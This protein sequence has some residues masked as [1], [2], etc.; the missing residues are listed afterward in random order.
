MWCQL[1][2]RFVEI[3]LRCRRHAV[4]VLAEE[5][6]VHVKLK[7]LV[8]AQGLFQPRRQND[9]FYLALA[10]PVAGQQKV[11]HH[12]LGDRRGAAHIL[13][14][15]YN[16]IAKS[17][18]HAG[19]VIALVAV[20]MLVLGADEGLFNH[21]RDVFD[22]YEQ[23]PF[24]RKFVEDPPFAVVNPA[25]GGGR[26]LRQTLMAGQVIGIHK[27]DSADGKGGKKDAHREHGE[28]AAKK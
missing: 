22:R 23:P 2:Q 10:G 25:D 15:R 27:K 26:I 12:L 5:N 17:A 18:D 24:L 14:A 13:A 16:R 21:L 28:Q 8:L 11:L 19:H 1:V 9:L 3:G 6:L 20:E 7:D 4:R